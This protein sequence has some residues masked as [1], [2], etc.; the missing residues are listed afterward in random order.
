[1]ADDPQALP[2][3]DQ[4]LAP[5]ARSFFAVQALFWAV[6]L[7]FGAM[8]GGTALGGVWAVA[9]PVAAT[10][11]GAIGVLVV[12]ALTVRRWRWA[13]RDEEL[14]L[15]HGVVTTQRT[16]VP[17]ARID[18]VETTRGF[19]AQNTFGVASLTVHTAA[20]ATT[21]PALPTQVADGLRDR[22]AHLA[23]TP[24]VDAQADLTAGPDAG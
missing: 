22:I 13:L 2:E 17:M 9:V 3:P 5:N 11:L 8:A 18:H 12:P 19:L 20:G 21:V 1:M 15:R 14:D 4:P 6:P 10:A 7:F 23:R 24:D 16:V